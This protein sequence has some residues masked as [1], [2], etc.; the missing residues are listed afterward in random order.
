MFTPVKVLRYSSHNGNLLVSHRAQRETV[1]AYRALIG[2]VTVARQL[3]GL[4]PAEQG[5]K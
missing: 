4:T 1:Y 5:A 2:V 3:G